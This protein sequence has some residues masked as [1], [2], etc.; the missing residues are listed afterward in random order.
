MQQHAQYCIVC[1]ASPQVL[2]YLLT[3]IFRSLLIHPQKDLQ[4]A[5]AGK[6]CILEVFLLGTIIKG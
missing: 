2:D 5:G 6:R 4:V 3:F 1:T